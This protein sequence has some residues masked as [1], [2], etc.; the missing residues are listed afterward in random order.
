M[1]TGDYQLRLKRSF[2]GRCFLTRFTQ[3]TGYAGGSDNV[4]K[5]VNQGANDW[6]DS[7]TLGATTVISSSTVN[8]LRFATN[9]AT[10]DNYQTPFFSPK[11]IGANVYSYDPGYMV[12]NVSP[13]FSLYPANQ[14]RA[15]FDNDTYQLA[16]DLTVVRGNH[17]FGVGAN[18]Q[19]WRGHY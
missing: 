7:L 17:Q 3:Q 10:V 12:L 11:D 5:T 1:A 9:K 14:A 19:F 8:S 15:S 6:S 2:F 16:E 18:T 4:L 13:A